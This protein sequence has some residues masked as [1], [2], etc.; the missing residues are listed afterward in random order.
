MTQ[1]AQSGSQEASRQRSSDSVRHG[2]P[3]TTRLLHHERHLAHHHHL[4]PD[5]H[6]EEDEPVGSETMWVEKKTEPISLVYQV[7]PPTGQESGD[8]HHL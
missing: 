7:L 2:D 6:H 4:H 8:R 3:S 5:H 1:Y